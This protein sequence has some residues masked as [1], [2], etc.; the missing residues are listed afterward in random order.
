[1]ISRISHMG[2]GTRS[3]D[4]VV[5]LYEDLFGLHAAYD[6][7]L[8]EAGQRSIFIPVGSQYIE[9]WEPLEKGSPPD[10][11]LEARGGGLSHIAFAV[12]DRAAALKALNEKGANYWEAPAVPGM[13]TTLVH[14]RST[15]G[16]LI[17]LVSKNLLPAIFRLSR[18]K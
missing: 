14:P 8:P 12:D 7:S 17:E 3:A 4:E 1:M 15:G 9:V 11:S 18:T 16:V 6:I 13:N 5:S 10:K 2:H